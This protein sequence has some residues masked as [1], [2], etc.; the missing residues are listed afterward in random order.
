MEVRRAYG[1]EAVREDT[2][3]GPWVWSVAR[4]RVCLGEE[5]SSKVMGG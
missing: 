1:M 5:L 4:V 2:F 3:G